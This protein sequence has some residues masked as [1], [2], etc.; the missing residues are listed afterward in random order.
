MGQLPT[1]IG[2]VRPRRGHRALAPPRREPLLVCG[3]GEPVRA[4]ALGAQTAIA[5]PGASG[6]ALWPA[7]AGV[8]AWLDWG[9]G[10]TTH[11]EE[12]ANE[13]LR[14]ESELGGARQFEP[15]FG[16]LLAIRYQGRIRE[17]QRLLPEQ[18]RSPPSA[19]IPSSSASSTPM[20]CFLTSRP[21]T[22]TAL[23]SLNRA[24]AS[25]V[26]M[27]LKRK[28]ADART[29][30]PSPTSVWWRALRSPAT[31]SSPWEAF[32]RAQAWAQLVSNRRVLDNSPLWMAGSLFDDEPLDALAL[33]RGPTRRLP[34]RRV[35]GHLWHG[36]RRPSRTADQGRPPPSPCWC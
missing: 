33:I 1:R 13:A 26:S 3:A 11:A 24:R 25:P 22:T 4:P 18:Q 14:V 15:A 2:V 16:R 21:P 32:D 31:S 12:L 28:R 35:L 36:A 5:L 23:V 17:F 30:S 29:S 8:T 27:S 19:G 9:V 7:A 6:H 20:S 10:N 34:R